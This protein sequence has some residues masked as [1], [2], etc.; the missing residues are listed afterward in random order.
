MEGFDPKIIA[1]IVIGALFLGALAVIAF[2]Y[3]A[4]HRISLVSVTRSNLEIRTNDLTIGHERR[5][6]IER[7][8][9]STRKS[10]RRATIGLM[11]LDPNKYDMSAEVML[12]IR[13][14]NQPLIYAAYENHHTRELDSEGVGVYIADKALD[15]SQAVSI[16]RKH[17]PELTDTLI[18]Q[19]AHCWIKDIL[20]PNQL[21]ACREKIGYYQSMNERKDVS[22][23][24]K[25]ENDRCI[26]KNERYIK[27]FLNLKKQS[28]IHNINP[29]QTS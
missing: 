13:E 15:V 25:E 24:I 5:D 2:M 7:I 3:F 21:R 9:S 26:A 23:M 4:H 18:N 28:N 17:F 6:K 22:R 20:I 10:I 19:H 12:V 16:F 11:I 29:T 1:L 8:D 14:A 27:N